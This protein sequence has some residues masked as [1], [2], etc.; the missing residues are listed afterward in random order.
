MDDHKLYLTGNPI[1]CDCELYDFVKYV[2]ES[3][4]KS[5]RINDVLYCDG[6]NDLKN[7]SIDDIHLDQLI[8][9]VEE[10]CP[11]YCDC[12]WRRHDKTIIV[13]C[14]YKNLT[15]PPY[16]TFKG[17]NVSLEVNLVGNQLMEPPT[18]YH[19]YDNVT[20][21]YLAENHIKELSWLPPKLQVIFESLH[22]QLTLIN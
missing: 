10:Q 12:F 21:L 16:L 13:D 14:S 2:Q 8:C 22:K 15:E 1:I 3:K 7:V 17:Q 19:G 20:Q 4:V 11:K 9:P 18:K 6:P 5:L